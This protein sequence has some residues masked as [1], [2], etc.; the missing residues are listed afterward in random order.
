MPDE[1]RRPAARSRAPKQPPW[2]AA[3]PRPCRG[4]VPRHRSRRTMQ[5]RQGDLADEDPSA[6]IAY[7]RWRRPELGPDSWKSLLLQPV[8]GRGLGV[9]PDSTDDGIQES[10]LDHES[11]A[12]KLRRL[13][14]GSSSPCSAVLWSWPPCRGPRLP[15]KHQRLADRRDDVP[16]TR[17]AA[18]SSPSGWTPSRAPT[19]T[20][21]SR[22]QRDADHRSRQRVQASRSPTFE[23]VYAAG[24]GRRHR[25]AAADRRRRHR[26]G[27]RH[28]AGDPRRGPC[29][30]AIWATRSSTIA[31]RSSD[32]VKVNGDWKSRRLQAR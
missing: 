20:T 15:T 23:Q 16:L 30:V 8:A 13:R 18:S 21:T 3:R 4:V 11:S 19:S 25:R 27:L 28:R 26:R 1:R 9:E 24:Q 6:S 29:Q 10:E 22:H 32:L 5:D 7:D 12:P 14:V 17:E 31:V 2:R